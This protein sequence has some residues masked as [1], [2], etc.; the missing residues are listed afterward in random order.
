M[1]RILLPTDF[2]FNS[3]NA[4]FYS[5]NLYKDEVCE[6]TLL[7]AYQVNGYIQNSTL[8]PEPGEKYMQLEKQN[9]EKKLSKLIGEIKIEHPNENHSF[10]SISQNTG[11]VTFINE[12]VK[13]SSFELIVIGTQ[14]FTDSKDVA[15][16]TNTK[17][18]LEGVNNSP[19]FAIPSHIKFSKITE[20]VLA[21]GFKTNPQPKDY[22]FIKKLVRKTNSE[23]R[24][25]FVDEGLGLNAGQI[26]NRE[27]LFSLL[28]DVPFTYHSLTHVTIPVGIYSFSESRESNVIAFINRKHSFLEN[29]LFNPLFK[30]VGNYATI[31]VLIIPAS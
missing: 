11:L 30:S 1:I 2:S 14:G 20:I 24:V 15:F 21:T 22:S 10:I 3:R 17:Q 25:L 19:I 31:P 12:E 8:V 7:H 26:K 23:L 27:I 9:V 5:I 16:G 29:V 13:N 18:M 4:I 28:A 6:F